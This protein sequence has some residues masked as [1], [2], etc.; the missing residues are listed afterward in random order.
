MIG[1]AL[2][3]I[4]GF[5]HRHYCPISSS[6][7]KFCIRASTIGGGDVPMISEGVT[8]GG[9]NYTCENDMSKPPCYAQYDSTTHDITVKSGLRHDHQFGI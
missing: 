5:S 6:S 4:W 2:N 7:V 9:Y 3:L 1:S 8:L